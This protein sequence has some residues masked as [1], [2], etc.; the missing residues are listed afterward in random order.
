MPTMLGKIK[1]FVDNFAE[2]ISDVL[3]TDVIITDSNMNVVGSAFRYFSLYNDIKVGTL[4]A[5]VM[6]KNHNVLIRNKTKI[7]NCR[8]C[9]EFQICK[10]KGFIGVPIRYGNVV[11]GAIAL[12]LPASKVKILFENIDSTVVFMERMAE[13]VA[14]RIHYR[15]EKQDLRKKIAQIETILDMM[16]EALMY[17]DQYGNIIYYNQKFRQDFNVDSN[18]LEENIIS[19]YSAFEEWY[20]KKRQMK[21]VKM[22]IQNGNTKFFGIVNSKY[23][24]ITEE[25]YGIILSFRPYENIYNNSKIFS[26]GTQVTFPWL[27]KMCDKEALEV[28]EHVAEQDN[29]VLISGDDNTLNEM[30]AKATYNHSSRR[31]AEIRVLHINNAYRNLLNGFFNDE[32]GILRMMDGGTV[33]IVQPENIPLYVQEILAGVIEKKK[34]SF[35]QYHPVETDIRFMF[36]TETDLKE[37]VKNGKFSERL[38]LLISE[39]HVCITKSFHN[40]FEVFAMYLKNGIQYYEE[41]YIKNIGKISKEIQKE[42]WK[43]HRN[44]TLPELELLI[45]RIVREGLSVVCE[46]EEIRQK[47][48]DELKKEQI[49]KLMREGHSKQEICQMLK[50]SRTTLYRH[51]KDYGY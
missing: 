34:V 23:V 1:S 51:L 24:Y 21:D 15:M 45:E 2:V 13:L 11:L 36:C 5:D 25:E 20:E 42:I 40:N 3:D 14:T 19:L 50:I 35:P 7:E 49:L 46:K 32:T 28:A 33:V 10:M 39:N 22:F 37:L 16:D 17:T 18:L 44:K 8:K 48:I 31:L 4:I 27:K 12:I 41:I 9:R 30:V 38:Y 43:Q 47:S 29:A 26:I 6:V